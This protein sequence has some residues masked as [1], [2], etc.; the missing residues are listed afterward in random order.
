MCAD[1]SLKICDFGLS[2][3]VEP[4]KIVT[5]SLPSTPIAAV[6]ASNPTYTT[7]LDEAPQVAPDLS[8]ST[9]FA[10]LPSGPITRQDSDAHIAALYRNAAAGGLG[11]LDPLGANGLARPRPLKRQLTKHVVTRW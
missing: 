8:A 9:L 7:A 11:G 10:T 6:E 2:R 3:V 1:C 4:A 5:R